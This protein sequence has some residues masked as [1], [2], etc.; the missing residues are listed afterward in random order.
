MNTVTKRQ[1]TPTL[2][3]DPLSVAAQAY[4]ARFQDHA[5]GSS[6]TASD[7]LDI[8]RSQGRDDLPYLSLPQR[9]TEVWKYT[10]LRKLTDALLA[11]P[12]EAK[13][14]A[15][16]S[17]DLALPGST[18]EIS[19]GIPAL[20]AQQ[21]AQGISS[22]AEPA[23]RQPGIGKLVA[24][25]ALAALNQ[26]T[27]RGGVAID[28]PADT[29]L[30][31]PIN[32]QH[33]AQADATGALVCPRT[34]IN[35]G[36]HASATI[37]ETFIALPDGTAAPFTNAVTEIH[38]GVGAKLDHVRVVT[39]SA[40]ACGNLGRLWLRAGDHSRY[41]QHALLCGGG[42]HREE[43]QA[44]LYAAAELDIRGV[45]LTAGRQHLDI[46]TQINHVGRASTSSVNYRGLA[47]DR[48]RLIING[49]IHLL[50]TAQ[51]TQAAYENKNLLLSSDAEINAKP[52]LEIYADDVKC[53]HGATVGKIDD[54]ALFYLQ[55]RGVPAEAARRL[56]IEGFLSQQFE[57]LDEQIRAPLFALLA[58]QLE[59]ML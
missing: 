54:D 9:K 5:A 43:L 3:A 32:L 19:N 15:G 10:S 52:E 58:P 48:S 51:Q 21:Q 4:A 11:A 53:A 29:T 45:A 44:E 24:N 13:P 30:A 23:P 39:A 37:V 6:A 31:Q 55:A 35:I 8:L 38:L 34:V 47:T 36:A 27:L 14:S 12:V 49:R 2:P 7:A 17:A 50:P 56:L 57:Q 25:D 40:A 26:A 22:L 33:R 59:A 1:T 16:I 41:Q 18:I 46:S 20:N 28:I 42:L